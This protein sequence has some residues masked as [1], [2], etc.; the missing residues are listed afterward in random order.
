MIELS[1][2]YSG[3]GRF[4]CASRHDFELATAGLEQGQPIR[5]KITK[6]RSLSQ[7]RWAFHMFQAAYDNQRAGPK[8]PSW[9]HLRK[10]L[11][12]QAGHCE[13]TTLQPYA[14]DRQAMWLMRKKFALSFE[15]DG[16][17]IYVKE[18]KSISFKACDAD[19]MTRVANAVVDV[20][21]EQIV[22]GTS[23]KDWEPYLPE[24]K[25]RA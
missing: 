8:L 25:R 21:C 15:T 5:A 4:T 12:I 3:Q 9:E 22:P 18:A 6:P 10:W 16:N 20:I 17:Y 24:S 23:R 11:L 1:L 2:I 13:V 7:H 19:E 14:M